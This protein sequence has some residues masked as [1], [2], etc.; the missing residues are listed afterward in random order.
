[1]SWDVTITL[2]CRETDNHSDMSWDWQSHWHVVRCDNHIDMS[3]DVT[4][5]LTYRDMSWDWQ[6]HWH[7]V[8]LTITLTIILICHKM[9][10]SHGHVV[11]CD[12]HID[13]SWNVTVTL[14]CREMWQS[15]W[16]VVIRM[17]KFTE[18]R[19]LS[20]R[21]VSNCRGNF[22]TCQSDVIPRTVRVY[23]LWCKWF[24]DVQKHNTEHIQYD[25]TSTIYAHIVLRKI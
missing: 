5:T 14:T 16:H 7:V 21:Y 4:I 10:Q 3:W 12:N 2:T 18:I 25:S 23:R 9:W 6:S 24:C 19:C 8:R 11:R 22:L 15:H 13:M 17:W 1:M 20:R